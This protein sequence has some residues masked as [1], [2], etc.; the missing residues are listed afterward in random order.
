MLPVQYT[1][2]HEIQTY[3]EDIFIIDSDKLDAFE[4]V[5]ESSKFVRVGDSLIAVSSIKSVRPAKQEISRLEA[6]LQ[7]LSDEVKEKVR[8]KVRERE[9]EGL[10]NSDWA[11]KN[12]IE[13]FSQ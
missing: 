3:N 7:G 9:K 2:K 13:A 8:K 1:P 5:M 11:I 10:S 6:L 12:I 4:K